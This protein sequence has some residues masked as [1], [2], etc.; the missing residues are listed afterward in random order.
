M[1]TNGG[2]AGLVSK[3]KRV[4]GKVGDPS[5]HAEL[6]MINGFDLDPANMHSGSS[7]YGVHLPNAGVGPAKVLWYPYK[8]EWPEV[9]AGPN[10]RVGKRIRVKMIR[11]KGFVHSS[12]FLITQ[13]RWRIVLY[14]C[15]KHFEE[16]EGQQ[17]ERYNMGWVDWNY[18]N[19]HN[20]ELPNDPGDVQAAAV[21]NYYASYF[22]KEA[23][24]RREI[25]RRILVKGVLNPSSD[26]GNYNNASHTFSGTLG[27]AQLFGQI[28]SY[29]S[30]GTYQHHFSDLS[31]SDPA[32]MQA[33]FPID[34][35]V[36]M[37][38]NIDCELYRYVFQIESDTVIGQNAAGVFSTAINTSNFIFYIVPHIYYTDE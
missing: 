10:N 22:N 26:I 23:I 32:N 33:A 17:V 37:N 29:K 14:R 38:D 30:T 18:E 1:I 3:R 35:T 31:I 7:I 13:V 36:E 15:L 20:M 2:D 27:D 11:L 24:Q 6:K 12:P 8:L 16:E 25:K 5:R 4:R 21:F 19:F 28:S 34:I 9:G